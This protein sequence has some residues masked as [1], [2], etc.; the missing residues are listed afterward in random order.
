MEETAKK[1]LQTTIKD[2]ITQY[3][4]QMLVLHRIIINLITLI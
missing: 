1:E 4:I 2:L 3:Y